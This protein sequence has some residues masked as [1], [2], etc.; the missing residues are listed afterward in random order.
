MTVQELNMA[1]TG[2]DDT[3]LSAW[4]LEKTI[5]LNRSP[6]GGRY[7]TKPTRRKI[8]VL[9]LA[10]CLV[11]ALAVT[12]YAVVNILGIREMLS[13]TLQELPPEVEP[14]ITPETAAAKAEEGWR[15]ALTQSLYTGD[16]LIIT[17][18]V[19]GGDQYI[20]VPTDCGNEDLT[21]VIGL[22]GSQTLQEYADQQG[23]KLLF[24]G[25]S[26]DL[27]GWDGNGQG[28]LMKNASPTEMTILN[29][30][31]NPSGGPESLTGTCTVYVRDG[32]EVFRQEFPLTLTAAPQPEGETRTFSLQ[33]GD[34]PG[35][36]FAEATLTKTLTGYKFQMPFAVVDEKAV[37][38]YGK[39]YCPELDFWGWLDFGSGNIWLEDLPNAN[40]DK[41]TLE[42]RDWDSV[43]VGS[44]EVVES[45]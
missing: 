24:A 39:L 9:I 27:D 7:Q 17:V 45:K 30:S 5:P 14:Y 11:F 32:G 19:S 22:D 29:T 10:A 16:K 31:E 33:S 43:P 36:R 35:L 21:G 12:A 44:I 40:F 18:T 2:I 42:V 25:A 15:C 34:V 26:V 4:E 41:L 37:E 6:K 13:G 8:W 23:K 28:Q 1:L 3:Y 38:N 20:V